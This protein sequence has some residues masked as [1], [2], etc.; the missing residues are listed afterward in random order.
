MKA[1]LSLTMFSLKSL[2]MY[3][4][5][6]YGDV[7]FRKYQMGQGYVSFPSPHPFLD[8]IS[9]C[10]DVMQLSHHPDNSRLDH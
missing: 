2:A 8:I 4:L 10:A 1:V 3:F 6:F 5:A 7:A 9:N